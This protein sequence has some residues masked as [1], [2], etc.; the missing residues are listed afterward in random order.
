M[1]L[2]GGQEDNP[3][4]FPSNVCRSNVPHVVTGNS[5]THRSFKM[6]SAEI[7]KLRI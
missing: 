1:G 7:V 3:I 6:S 5:R 4:P 2:F